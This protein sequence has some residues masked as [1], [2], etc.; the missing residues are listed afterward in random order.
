MAVG[1]IEVEL[2][3][4]GIDETSA[5]RGPWV[6]NMWM[7][8][9]RRDWEVRPGFGQV[10][11]FDTTMSAQMTSPVN[12]GYEKHLGSVCFVTDWGSTQI[13][14]VLLARVQTGNQGGAQ[15]SVWGR[16][17]AVSIFDVDSRKRREEILHTH[18]SQLD[19]VSMPVRKGCYETNASVDRQKFIGA[20]SED[21]SFHVHD[22][23]V[24]INSKATGLLVYLPA[25]F[26][27][28]NVSAALDVANRPNWYQPMSESSLIIPLTPANGIAP[29]SYNYRN[30]SEIPAVVDMATL[31][32]RMVLA[33]E[34][35]LYFSDPGMPNAYAS[36]NFVVAPTTDPIVAI[37]EINDNLLV[38]TESKTFL[39]QPSVGELASDGR[40]ITA[41]SSTGCS[42]RESVVSV[43]ASV[44]WCASDG[45]HTTT[46]GMSVNEV[47][48]SI[49]GFFTDSVTTPLS[50]YL[51]ASGVADP[52]TE[53][54]P[55]TVYRYDAGDPVS[56]MYDSQ[57]GALLASFPESGCVWCL[58][59]GQW[60]MWITSS[61]AAQE[62]GIPIVRDVSNIKS[63]VCLTNG[64]GDIFCVGSID[65]EQFNDA[66]TGNSSKSLSYYITELGRGG[67]LDRSTG[68]DDGEDQRIVTS[69]YKV[70]SAVGDRYIYMHKPELDPITGEYFML[71][72]VAPDAVITS[73]DL[74]F[75]INTH[76][77]IRNTG[78]NID[79]CLPPERQASSA[80]YGATIAAGTATISYAGVAL[81]APIGGR[82]PYFVI[83]WIEN[84]SHHTSIGMITSFIDAKINGLDAE[85]YYWHGHIGP[86]DDENVKA[87]AVDWAY[88]SAQVGEDGVGQT[89]ARGVFTRMLSHGSAANKLAPNWIWGVYNTLSAG[90]WKGWSSQ[91]V[92]YDNDAIDKVADKL[93]VRSRF[94]SSAGVLSK[95][96][97]NNAA[98][99]GEYLIDDE[100]YDTISTS[101]ST[102][103]EHVTYMLFGFMRNRAE[104]MVISSA[105]LLLRGNQGG[106]RRTGR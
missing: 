61:C 34:G 26:R 14:S 57:S 17:L 13:L 50:H 19:G 60:S 39:Y 3:S 70:R 100:E 30:A 51:T 12:W 86:G 18:T 54:M 15:G 72:E 105:K 85:V 28:T 58:T 95:R 76:W 90:D 102:R 47:S 97:F 35:E 11:A 43:G 52:L 22:G 25:D 66:D 10:C 81:N 98:K 41:S 83:R 88:K 36:R 9:G 4:G 96:T 103:G 6:Q 38:F 62:V 45:I 42:S 24:Y 32:N 63:P 80:G 59:Q 48:S 84:H 68:S 94:K 53:D 20:T 104:R 93:T 75:N 91:V 1:G 27:E 92:D 79:M 8:D 69:S 44:F 77:D 101:D 82:S 89:R 23:A 73:V 55:K 37:E 49:R 106:R 65:E 64:R 16:Y 74:V 40:F 78:G 99:F 5:A 46:N 71:V 67:A 31:Q 87:Q 33:S 2:L 21:F 7:P 56:I 29:E